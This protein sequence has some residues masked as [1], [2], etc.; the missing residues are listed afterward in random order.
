MAH[1]CGIVLQWMNDPKCAQFCRNE[2][3]NVGRHHRQ[4]LLCCTQPFHQTID[5]LK[6]NLCF[7]MYVG[8]E[9]DRRIEI[10]MFVL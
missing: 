9:A 7:V 4:V 8:S 3:K 5:E 1:G 2:K 6:P 10:G